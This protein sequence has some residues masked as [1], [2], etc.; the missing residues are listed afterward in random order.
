MSKNV[1]QLQ[2]KT[3][4]D[5]NDFFYTI[6]S[7]ESNASLKN[8]KIKGSTLKAQ[9]A[10]GAEFRNSAGTPVAKTIKTI[11]QEIGPW[12]CVAQNTLGVTVTIPAL[13]DNI[14]FL[15]VSAVIFSDLGRPTFTEGYN[16]GDELP[17]TLI[18]FNISK[19]NV[20]QKSVQFSLNAQGSYL[21][22][23]FESTAFNRGFVKV[24]YFE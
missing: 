22:G 6:D 23:R 21:T 3:V 5:D 15:E 7:T 20:G 14:Q 4:L 2:E 18:N 11:Y 16:S 12:D 13:P 19:F 1:T 8:K 10:A 24:V 17:G 9:V